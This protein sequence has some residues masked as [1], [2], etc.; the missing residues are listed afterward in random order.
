MFAIINISGKQYKTQ[1]G[2]R[3]RVPR[4]TLEAGSK[5]TFE[6]ILLIIL[7]LTSISTGPVGGEPFPFIKVTPLIINC[8]KGP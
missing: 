7:F 5:I 3:L 6:D 2:T 1:I 8:S 4:Q